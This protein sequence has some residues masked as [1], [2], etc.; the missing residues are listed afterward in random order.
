ME[1][2]IYALL[3]SNTGTD[4]VEINLSCSLKELLKNDGLKE[5]IELLA[6]QNSEWNKVLQGTISAI[7][8]N[9]DDLSEVI[10]L[11]F[12]S[13]D[14][15][16]ITFK[17]EDLKVTDKC[18]GIVCNDDTLDIVKFKTSK[19]LNSLTQDELRKILNFFDDTNTG[20]WKDVIND[21]KPGVLINV[22]DTEDTFCLNIDMKQSEIEKPLY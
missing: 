16:T 11:N 2:K 13:K 8:F 15:F 21:D 10:K 6:K 1:Q 5:L 18:V 3:L 9:S 7:L 17:P 4:I 20:N 22:D 14:K 19:K 12:S